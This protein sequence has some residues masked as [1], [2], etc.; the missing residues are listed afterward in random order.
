M[1]D[2]NILIFILIL[3]VA[4]YSSILIWLLLHPSESVR[5]HVRKDAVPANVTDQKLVQTESNE[6]LP[7]SD[8]N[9]CQPIKGYPHQFQTI[10]LIST[11]GSGNTWV[12]SL[13]EQ[14]TGYLSGSIYNDGNLGKILKGEMLDLRDQET[15][16]AKG[17]VWL[18]DDSS[19]F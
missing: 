17:Q 15:I 2:Q 19:I 9:P 18:I 16:V 3:G 14:A 12:R 11:P 7:T 10:P 8:S 5:H 6:T 13:I 1:Q 4:G